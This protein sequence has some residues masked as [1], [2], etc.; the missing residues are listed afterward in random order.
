MQESMNSP[1]AVRDL[2]NT[3]PDGAALR[4]AG[5]CVRY[6]NNCHTLCDAFGYGPYRGGA[7]I[8]APVAAPQ[9]R[10]SAASPAASRARRPGAAA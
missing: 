6:N 10:S 8:T 2:L 9:R 3:H 1:L 7:Q 5:V 4:S